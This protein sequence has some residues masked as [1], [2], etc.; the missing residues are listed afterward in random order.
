[1]TLR[2]NVLRS[3]LAT[4]ASGTPISVCISTTRPTTPGPSCTPAA[5]SA[6]EV[7]KACRAPAP[8]LLDETLTITWFKVLF[9]EQANTAAAG[10]PRLVELLLEAFAATLPSVPVAGGARQFTTQPADLAVLLLDALVRRIT[11]AP[12]LR[13]IVAGDYSPAKPTKFEKLGEIWHRVLPQRRLDVRGD[14]ILVQ[15]I[16]GDVSY[17]AADLSD[18]ERA[19]F[20]LI[21]QTLV[22]DANALIIDEP[23]LHVHRSIMDRLWDE[24]EAA[25]PES[26][27][28]FITHDL[29][30]AASR[31]AQKFIVKE[32]SPTAAWTLE[33][34]PEA[35]GF[36]EQ[37]TTLILGSRQPILFV[38]GTEDSLDKAIYRC[39]FPEWTVMPRGSCED[40]IH[41][42]VSMKNNSALTRVTCTGVVDADDYQD[43][44][45]GRLR[46]LGV[47]VLPV[48]E[49]ENVVLLPEVSRV[50]AENE[51]YEGEELE[52][53]LRELEE[54][55]FRVAMSPEASDAVVTRYC[56]RRIDRLLKKVNLSAAG[57]VADITQEFKR[58][59]AMIC[60]T[61]IAKEARKRLSTAVRERD[62]RKLLACYDNKGL[63]AL[64]ARHL[65]GQSA[66]NFKRWF[67]RVLSNGTVPKLDV[68]IR[69]ALPQVG[70]AEGRDVSERTTQPAGRAVH[71]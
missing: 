62:L 29:E 71:Q 59:M 28:V 31:T 55:V 7:C 5:P 14:D 17:S 36:D 58:Q 43:D 63:F 16:A 37:V 50:I 70:L 12:G 56:R 52:G 6:S 15:D 44:D 24:L 67:V 42:V 23:E 1:M 11:L 40:V 35:T 26:V 20:Y 41:S 48:S 46:D 32:Y 47:Q 65:R 68:A 18:G 49:I 22:T 54:A 57:N 33:A 51:G 61:T 30:F 19:V 25:R 69:A 53:C 10:P 39:I 9:A 8:A 66:K 13:P 2:L 21:G 4:F 38:E 3:R 60:V 45:I 64:A 27:F 34:V